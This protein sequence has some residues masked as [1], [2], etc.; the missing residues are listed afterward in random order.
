M[1][2]IGFTRLVS[3]CL[4]TSVLITGLVLGPGLETARAAGLL[5]L[6]EAIR[7]ALAN[8]PKIK[9]NQAVVRGAV[10]G[11]K[12]VRAGLFPQVNGYARYDRFSDPV[13]V[14]PIQ[15]LHLPPPLFSRDQY[16]AGL[17]FRVP[18]YEG[19]RLRGGIRAATKDE[20]IARAG[21]AYSRENLI[22]A[23]TDTF[24]SILYL[25]SLRRAK[26]KTLAAIE[27]TRKEA[28]LR[29][30]LGRI[31]PLDLMEID[32]QVASERVDLVR[33]RET[34]KRAG[35]QLC[36]LLGRSPETGIETRGSLEKNGKEE[37]DLV[38]SLTGP[39]GRKRLKA[40]IGKRP[41]IL[42]AGKMVEKADES[43]KI[44]KG[45]RLP[46]VDLVGDY[47]RHAGSGLDGEE[48]RWSA[49]IHVSLNIF[50]SGLIAAKVAGAMAK[51]AAAAEALKGLVLKA[52]SQVYAALS[53]LREAGARIT[54]ADQARITA[55]EAYKIETL[56]Y[57]KGTGTVT[58]L[59]KAQA[60]W[61]RAK[62]Q[63]IRALFDRQQAVTALRLATAVIRPAGQ[64]AG[65]Q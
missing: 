64:S 42:R 26:E 23:V 55:G 6:D 28:A 45:L 16:Q 12:A 47:G 13:S 34:L 36:L 18:L 59:L 21:L 8:S 56:R 7:I 15:G 50:N 22:A 5:T 1:D 60:A 32:T 27:E 25:K 54:L 52:E 39:S 3:L 51:R 19:G 58:D 33:T 48:G 44:A 65:Q 62:A 2:K 31:A 9:E 17:S 43:L 53:S 63:Y 35:Q 46:S 49:G 10:S 38:A 40:C 29:L 20:G 24:N 41:D 4:L 11:R 57:R 30:K 37:A 14:V 61:W